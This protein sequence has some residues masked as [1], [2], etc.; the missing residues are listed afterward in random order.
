MFFNL[1]A[2]LARKG[3]SGI[4]I[5]LIIKATPK[6]VSNKMLGKTEFTRTE[7]FKIRDELFPDLSL[8]Y[9]FSTE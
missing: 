6:T 3:L 5:S 4:D 2:E 7:M 8:E 9:L 1:K